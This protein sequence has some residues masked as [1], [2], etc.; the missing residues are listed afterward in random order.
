VDGGATLREWCERHYE[1]PPD[2]ERPFVK[3]SAVMRWDKFGEGGID[4]RF[5]GCVWHWDG[6]RYCSRSAEI[7]ALR[8][9]A[10]QEEVKHWTCDIKD[11]D[12]LAAGNFDPEVAEMDEILTGYESLVA[13]LSPAGFAQN[14][15]Y[16]GIRIIHSPGGPDHFESFAWMD[17]LYLCNVDGAHHFA[18]ASH[19]AV[20]LQIDYALTGR[21]LIN[22]LNPFAVSALR[23]EFEIFWVGTMQDLMEAMKRLRAP[24]IWRRPPSGLEGV[25]VF[26]PR[27]NAKARQAAAIFRESL[28]F[29]VGGHLQAL[30]DRQQ[31]SAVSV[32][33]AIP[34]WYRVGHR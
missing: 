10:H 16:P 25:V 2:F 13:D 24:W 6:E 30:V 20:R 4:S 33:S 27:D 23:Q 11:V 31:F 15:A 21:L 34:A 12:G 32:P 22:Y 8:G 14:L 18:A 29:D 5:G 17:R 7:D 19:I 3:R 28:H 1:S 9:L 26:L